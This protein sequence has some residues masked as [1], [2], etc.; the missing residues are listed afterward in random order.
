MNI[1]MIGHSQSG[2]TSYMAGL[3]KLYGDKAEGF[4]L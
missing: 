1:L 3:Y 4:G 2:K